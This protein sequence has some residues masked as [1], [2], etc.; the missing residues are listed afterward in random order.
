MLLAALWLLSPQQSEAPPDESSQL[1]NVSIWEGSSDVTSG[2]PTYPPEAIAAKREGTVE[3]ELVVSTTGRILHGRLSKSA[4]DLLDRA[5]AQMVAR[6]RFS[7][8]K[9][10][11]G[12][13]IPVLLLARVDYRLPATAPRSPPSSRACP[14]RRRVSSVMAWPATQSPRT[15]SSRRPQRRFGS[16]K[17]PYSPQ[18]MKAKVI[19]DV[20][21]EVVIL[22]DGTIGRSRVVKSLEPSLDQQARLAAGYWLFKPA[23]L[24]GEPVT[25][26][27][28]ILV[29]FSLK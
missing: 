19:G 6:W 11:N 8:F 23:M 12:V 14:T 17:A 29:S 13:A 27:A 20:Q 3:I 18:A 25:V 2:A 28:N 15:A 22:A 9:N 7:P 4:G 1:Q 21:L 26:R 16:S 5:T 10:S 24:N